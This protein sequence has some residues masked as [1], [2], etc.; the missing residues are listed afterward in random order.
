MER[1]F[2][3]D[4]KQLGYGAGQVLQ[5]EGILAI[6]KAI[7]QSGVSYVGGYPGAPVSHLLDVLADANAP[8]LEPMGIY[9]E[10]SGS[11]AAAAALLGAS[12]NYPMRG[13]VTWKSVVGTNV[14]SDALSHVASA[15]VVGGALIVIGEDYGEGAS[16]LQERTHATALK[17]SLP[18]LDPQNS[19]PAFARF[20][21]EGFALSEACGQPVLFSIRIRAAH[22]RGT[23]L[24]KDNVAPRISLRS[25]MDHPVFALEKI[26]LPPFT[27]AMEAQK[28]EHRLPAARRYIR[29][30]GLNQHRRGAE[31]AIGIVM[32]G[33]QYNTT[34][35]ALATLGA[36]DPFGDTV[37]SLLVLNAIH[38]LVP[39]EILEFLENKRHV[40]VVEEGQPDLIER[41][42][43]AL[44][45]D[46]R[47]AVEIHGKDL[48]GRYGE[49]VSQVVTTG[50]KEFLLLARPTAVSVAEVE[51]RFGA[52][53]AH[54]ADL[55]AALPRPITR[56][57][58]TFCTG[59][60]ERP[61]FS[62]LKI[63]RTRQPEVGD[64]H[65]SADIGCHSFGT[66][67]P[68]N[69]GN[70]ILGYG[71][72]LASASAV[73]P[74]FAKRVVSVMGDGGFWHNGL[75]NGVANAVFNQQD[76]V[77]VILENF[78][79][80]ATG[81]QHNPST[82]KNARHEATPMTIPQ[83]LR[84]LGVRWIRTVNPYRIGELIGTLRR[85]LTTRAPGLKVVIARAE[86]QL[87]RQRREGPLR[88]QRIQ[89]GQRVSQ[90][91][92]G[93]D[94][95]VCTGDHSCMRFNGCP[96]LTLRDNPDPLRD[97]PIAHVDQS[98]V[99]CGVCGEVAHAAVLCPSFY[100]VRTVVNP[101]PWER[102]VQ[103]LRRR[104]IGALASA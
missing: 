66:Q 31:V 26:N 83:A 101:A 76:S 69:V 81:Q 40:L 82:G 33:G 78:Y 9:F 73:A 103:H 2:A 85:A 39:E 32:Q 11:E 20:V 38:P 53:N 71:M 7:L 52:L 47:L 100:E 72:G 70:T 18:L 5:G 48:F 15:G 4:V 56:R 84:G 93:V 67:A 1:S 36:A 34:L 87:E 24:C 97:D 30:R 77:L 99:G 94:P 58:P 29:E 3:D 42:V 92:F 63:L 12:V 43:K 86:C 50:L 80:S 88:R 60:P 17:S 98:C 46:A 23:L 28:Y 27:Y 22:M 104:V 96:S 54:R 91:R 19:L 62:A 10:A 8:L 57:P 65:V 13:V 44:A 59:C 35:R 51:R 37:V 49:Y 74:L 90:P 75:T 16:I 25:R 61:V 41:E 68:F 21:E 89:A 79:T 14:A 6:T 102:L 45:H 55:R 64:T 95:E